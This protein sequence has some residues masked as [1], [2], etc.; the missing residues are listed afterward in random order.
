MN[1]EKP[2]KRL[3]IERVSL[4]QCPACGKVYTQL[5]IE[6]AVMNFP[7]SCNQ[8]YMNDFVIFEMKEMTYE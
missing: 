5:E 7:C 2:R 6:L 4:R 8:A 1:N 3:N